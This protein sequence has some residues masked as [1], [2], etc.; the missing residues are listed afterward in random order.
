MEGKYRE[1]YENS[2]HTKELHGDLRVS[3]ESVCVIRIPM[4]PFSGEQTISAEKTTAMK[5]VYE[6]H[7]NFLKA[8]KV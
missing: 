7:A 1:I 8:L 6:N 5:I 2:T 4:L 3:V